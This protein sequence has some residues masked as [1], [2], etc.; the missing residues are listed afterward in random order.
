MGQ[1][2]Y[3]NTFALDTVYHTQDCE[4]RFTSN[5]IYLDKFQAD[6]DYNGA[7]PDDLDPADC[8]RMARRAVA[9]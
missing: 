1:S 7:L 2:K 8:R 6:Y 5:D 9:V 4:E 3:F